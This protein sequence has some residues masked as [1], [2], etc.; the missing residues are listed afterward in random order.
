ME[1]RGMQIRDAWIYLG[2]HKI[3]NV[4]NMQYAWVKRTLHI[5]NAQRCLRRTRKIN[6]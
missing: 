4:F 5:S 2:K 6:S 1:M 3:F